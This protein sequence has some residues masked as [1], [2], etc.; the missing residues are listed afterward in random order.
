MPKLLSSIKRFIGES[1]EAKAID[2][3]NGSTFLET[4]TG[5]MYVFSKA[6]SSWTLKDMA[7]IL[8]TDCLLKELLD[9]A[10]K[11]N[12]QLELVVGSLND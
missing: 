9:E 2:C 6:T 11:T 5:D 7:S 1:H 10:K 3:P 12:E 8:R 4:D